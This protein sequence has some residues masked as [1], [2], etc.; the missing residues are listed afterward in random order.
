K[1]GTTAVKQ[2][3]LN[4]FGIDYIGCR[5]W[6]DPNGMNCDP[7][8]GDTDCNV[9]LPM[10]CMKYDY[11]PRP[12]Y[13]IYGNGA[14]MPAA[15]YAGWNQGHVST[16]M[17]VKASRF[18]NRAQAS[19]FCATALGAGWEVV[20]IWSGQGKWISGMNGTKYAGAEW[21]AN[22][23]QMQSGGWHFYSYGNVRKDTRFWIHGPDDQSST[24]WSR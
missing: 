18:E 13:F 17:P 22:T 12:P 11:S 6:T 1:L 16:T 4:D 24:C 15:N 2:S 20:A 21:T 19:A 8:N 5:D 7:Y 3:H 14:A 23:G 9:E 10:L